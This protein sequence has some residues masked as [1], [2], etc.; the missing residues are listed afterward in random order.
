ML[1]FFDKHFLRIVLGIVAAA[2]AW[3]FLDS[4]AEPPHFIQ[5]VITQS[6]Y[7]PGRYGDGHMRILVRAGESESFVFILGGYRSHIQPGMRVDIS[8][9]KRRLSG[10]Y[11]HTFEGIAR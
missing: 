8:V 11:T 3:V 10:L 2:F 6:I 7:E 9:R 4:P 1:A 5:G